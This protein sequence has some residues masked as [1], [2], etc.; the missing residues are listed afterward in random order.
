MIF[1]LQNILLLIFVKKISK[2]IQSLIYR[3][4]RF[5]NFC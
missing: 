2:F 5:V 4:M 1:Y 3:L